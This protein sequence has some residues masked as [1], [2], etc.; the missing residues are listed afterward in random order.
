MQEIGTLKRNVVYIYIYIYIHKKI[1]F[2]FNL[3]SLIGNIWQKAIS[4]KLEYHHNKLID[5]GCCRHNNVV[6]ERRE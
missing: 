1:L 3:V 6:C 5:V 2:T 4:V